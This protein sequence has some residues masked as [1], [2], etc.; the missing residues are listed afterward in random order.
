MGMRG[1]RRALVALVAL[2]ASCR[3]DGARRA[4]RTR[5]L[6]ACSAALERAATLG[7]QRRLT[8]VARGCA[9]A[10]P[11]FAPWADRLDGIAPEGR[12]GAPV[13]GPRADPLGPVLDACAPACARPRALDVDGWADTRARCG[14][15]GLGIARE[16][17]YLASAD[18]WILVTIAR[19]LERERLGP[20]DDPQLAAQLEHAL[21]RTD[22]ALPLPAADAQAGYAL[23]PSPHGARTDAALF[24][25]VGAE[26]RAG[27]VPRG[28]L[29]GGEVALAAAP[30]GGFPGELVEVDRLAAALAEHA[31]LIR[32]Q[33]SAPPLVLLDAHVDLARVRAVFAGL[34][35]AQVA[36]AVATGGVAASHPVVLQQPSL[37]SV[38]SPTIT[39][40]SADL[41][42]VGFGDDRVATWA[43]LADE[44]GHFA[45][46]NAPVRKLVLHLEAPATAT[47]LVQLLDACA[48]AR[49]DALVLP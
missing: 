27:A 26:L 37:E 21:R 42:I 31:Q 1:N 2:V 35:T 41:A 47:E 36:V 13:D 30:S 4:Q 33:A 28:I 5:E 49:I 8:E 22:F 43:T 23:A 24:V 19:W 6:E 38:G 29:R 40:R 10:C 48:E 46:V 14:P 9:P 34:G 32:G 3:G 20:V 18:W 39:I 45:A 15:A 25:V 44:L 17:A 11:A 7:P 12:R 16:Q